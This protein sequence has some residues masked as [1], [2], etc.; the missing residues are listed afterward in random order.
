M[1]NID[2]GFGPL[3][4]EFWRLLFAM[5]RIGAAM[6]AAPFFGSGNVPAQVRVIASGAVTSAI[7]LVSSSGPRC[8]SKRRIVCARASRNAAGVRPWRSRT[9]R[10]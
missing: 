9:T 4:H 3:E 5:T 2:F 10:L 8:Q 7:L 6:L 1:I